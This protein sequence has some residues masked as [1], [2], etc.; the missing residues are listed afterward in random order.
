MAC[1]GE[2]EDTYVEI[3][4]LRETWVVLFKRKS[5][6]KEKKVKL[7]WGKQLVILY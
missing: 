2:K 1:F 5:K 3:N 4:Y 7:L 6:K